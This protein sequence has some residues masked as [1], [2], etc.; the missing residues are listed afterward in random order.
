METTKPFVSGLIS[1]LTST[2]TPITG[3]RAKELQLEILTLLPRTFEEH[4]I[5]ISA[6]LELMEKLYRLQDYKSFCRIIRHYESYLTP[7]ALAKSFAALVDIIGTP[8]VDHIMIYQC[9]VC[10]KNILSSNEESELPMERMGHCIS[11]MFRRCW[12]HRR[13]RHA[14]PWQVRSLIM[15][16]LERRPSEFRQKASN[17]TGGTPAS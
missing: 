12:E 14:P 9:A 5:N 4:Q 13:S 2:N 7:V 6:I 17:L 10:L 11:N 8:G 1:H 15:S 3:D 16:M